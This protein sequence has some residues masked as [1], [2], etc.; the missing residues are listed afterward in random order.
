MNHG[1]NA[2]P[3]SVDLIPTLNWI[4]K[5]A[6]VEHHKQ[7][8]FHLLRD[9]PDLCRMAAAVGDGAGGEGL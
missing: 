4:G 5:Q 7:V 6:V 1:L 2:T 9:T 8:P 3:G